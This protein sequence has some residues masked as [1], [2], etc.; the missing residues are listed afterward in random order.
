MV[1]VSPREY[2]ESWFE[3]IEAELKAGDTSKAIAQCVQVLRDYP[4]FIIGCEMGK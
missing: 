1:E 3:R 2:V 4:D